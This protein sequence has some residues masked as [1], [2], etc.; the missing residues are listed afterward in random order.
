MD[1]ECSRSCG[2]KEKRNSARSL[3]ALRESQ[4]RPFELLDCRE[5]RCRVIGFEV[6]V[7]REGQV[8][9]VCINC[10]TI[11]GLPLHA[12]APFVVW[13]ICV[14]VWSLYMEAVFTRKDAVARLIVDWLPCLV[15]LVWEG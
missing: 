9:L 4:C 1:R 5:R 14:Y 3:T 2:R 7:V 15:R 10:W 11:R 12:R 6:S 13:V 8:S